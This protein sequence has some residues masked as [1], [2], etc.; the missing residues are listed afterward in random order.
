LVPGK[1]VRLVLLRQK[2]SVLNHPA[3]DDE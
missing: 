2:Q 1:H 3:M